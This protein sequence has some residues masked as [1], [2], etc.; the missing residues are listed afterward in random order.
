[1][2]K[3]QSTEGTE[4]LAS[5]KALNLPISTKHSIEISRHLRYKT[6]AFAIRFL[7]DVVVQKQAVPFKRFKRDVGHKAGMSAGRY[8]QKAA[9]DFLKLVKSVE[10]NAQVKGLNTSS[11]KII[12]LIANKA[13]VPLTGG[14]H[15]RG[16]R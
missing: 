5:A 9:L 4:H 14:R 1:M 2:T 12:K 3:K 7:E 10:A 13:S 6:T 16:I 15:R 11:L 8:P